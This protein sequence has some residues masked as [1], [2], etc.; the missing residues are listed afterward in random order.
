[1]TRKIRIGIDVGGTF[2][3]A[4]ALDN[5]TME[6][7]GFK[8]VQTTHDAKEG[9]TKGIVDILSLLLKEI[10]CNAN[11]VIF[12]AHGTTQ[13]TNALLEGDVAE[14]G[15]VGMGKGFGTGK[16]KKDTNLKNVS[17]EDDKQIK[18]SYQFINTSKGIN[19]KEVLEVLNNFRKENINVSV[20]SEAFSVD[21]PINEEAVAEV[22]RDNGMISTATH[23]LSKLYGLKARTKTAVINA[24]ILPKMMQTADM[25]GKAVKETKIRAPLMIMR[26]DGGVM[27]VDEVK[28]RPILTVLSG[29]AAGVAGA[30]MY[31]KITDGIFLEVGGTS[32]DISAIKNGKVLTKFAN[33]GGHN[34]YIQSL[35]IHTIG[36]GGG[37]MIRMKNQ[38]IIDVGPRSAHIAGLPYACFADPKEL[39]G[40]KLITIGSKHDKTNDFVAIEALN[41]KQYALT[42]TC[43]AN[44]LKYVKQGDYAFGNEESVRITFEIIEKVLNKPAEN[45]ANDIMN[46]IFR[47]IKPAIEG[48]VKEYDLSTNY[49]ELVGGGGGASNVV[50]VVAEKMGIKH[51]I[52]K[53]APVIATIG[54]ALAMMRESI[55]RTIVNPSQ[56]DIIRI[57]N[58]VEQAVIKAGAAPSSIE[59]TVDID[60]AKSI[61]H[62]VAVGT[63]ELSANNNV[64]VDLSKEQLKEKVQEAFSNYNECAIED[65]YH[66]STLHVYDINV[67]SGKSKLFKKVMNLTCVMDHNGVIKLTME[68]ANHFKLKTTEKNLLSDY[69]EKFTKFDESGRVMPQIYLLLNGKIT[70]LSGMESLEQIMSLTDLEIQRIEEGSEFLLLI[71]K[72]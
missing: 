15:I 34:I 56:D 31:E 38:K 63:T 66:S 13:A 59:V 42:L 67:K 23:E 11:D 10:Q 16:I 45:I 19:S 39:K 36:I 62:A 5:D 32:T 65:V 21:N 44:F 69:I 40:A 4:I 20:I 9:V 70:D 6:I 60:N 12:I 43:V 14:V 41:G 54:A 53:N 27:Q 61:V 37:S 33:I 28:K 18:T 22:F 68:D 1:M 50:P 26:S 55:E 3:D 58:E 48:F 51:R 64:G 46:I 71:K 25:T 52:A 72:R 29:P 7:I 24:S 30:L 47:K 35:D 49:L 17:L 8:K 57:R 2:T